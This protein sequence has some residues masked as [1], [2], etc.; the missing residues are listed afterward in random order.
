ME[1]T[2]KIKQEPDGAKQMY[3]ANYM[4]WVQLVFEKFGDKELIIG[5]RRK[6][7]IRTSPQNRYLHGVVIPCITAELYRIGN[8]DITDEATKGFLKQKYAPKIKLY[9]PDTGEQIGEA[10]KRTRDFS[11]TEMI[12]FLDS[13][14]RWANTTLHID[15]PEPKKEY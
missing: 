3:I 2:A 12:D 8:A 10:V 4:A 11:K 13:I 6:E 5:A 7:R 1:T 14:I 9:N 15:I